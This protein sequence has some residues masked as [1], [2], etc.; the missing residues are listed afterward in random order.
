LLANKK[1]KPGVAKT[2]KN[3]VPVY[4]NY[5]DTD[6]YKKNMDK[7]FYDNDDLLTKI[8]NDVVKKINAYVDPK[9][10]ALFDKVLNSKLKQHSSLYSKSDLLTQAHAKTSSD[11]MKELI[12]KPELQT[13]RRQQKKEAEEFKNNTKRMF[14]ILDRLEK[15]KR[16]KK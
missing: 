14:D 15:L 8:E 9:D 7:L 10:K 6:Y 3:G 11:R 13:S 12:K 1:I 16:Y 4:G 5:S 2:L